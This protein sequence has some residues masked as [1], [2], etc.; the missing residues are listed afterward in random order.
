MGKGFI[1]TPHGVRREH[2]RNATCCID[3]KDARSVRLVM[4]PLD[5]QANWT[6]VRPFLHTRA[7]LVL[8]S[9]EAHLQPFCDDRVTSTLSS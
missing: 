7:G 9:V 3:V 4:M 8:S 5:Q 2:R 1:T 6:A